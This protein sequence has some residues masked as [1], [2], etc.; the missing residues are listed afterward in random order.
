MLIL[1]VIYREDGVVDGSALATLER[2]LKGFN[3]FDTIEK[4]KVMGKVHL[5]IPKFKIETTIHLSEV[6]KSLGM[7]D[8]FDE[9]AADFGGISEENLVVTNAIQK[10]FIEVDEIG[11]T[12]AAATSLVIG[13]RSAARQIFIADHPFLFFVRDLQT[14]LLLF[15]GRLANPTF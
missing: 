11:T 15:Q 10:A 9:S 2:K 8:M 1:L 5:E 4:E 7:T 14:G 6:L 12:A 3:V 13:T